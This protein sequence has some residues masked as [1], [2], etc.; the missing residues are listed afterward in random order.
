[1]AIA[2]VVARSCGLG[3][4]CDARKFASEDRLPYELDG[5]HTWKAAAP[6]KR[7]ATAWHR[8]SERA[9][10]GETVIDSASFGGRSRQHRNANARRDHVAYRF[11]RASFEAL[12]HAFV[13]CA[14]HARA[15]LE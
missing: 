15:G 13:R 12:L 7:H 14:L 3:K 4:H 5:A 9:D 2:A 11:E 8:R 10:R 6:C 1:M